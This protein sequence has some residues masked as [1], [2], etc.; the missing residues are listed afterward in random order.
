MSGELTIKRPRLT[1]Y[2]TFDTPAVT[3]AQVNWIQ[4]L[5]RLLGLTQADDAVFIWRSLDHGFL[6]DLECVHDLVLVRLSVLGTAVSAADEAIPHLRRDDWADLWQEAAGYHQYVIDHRDRLKLLGATAVYS[7]ISSY[8]SPTEWHDLV[9]YHSTS[10]QR[11]SLQLPIGELW[12]MSKRCE[13]IVEFHYAIMVGCEEKYDELPYQL[14]YHRRFWLAE[15]A[16]FRLQKSWQTKNDAIEQQLETS[17][18]ILRRL[19]DYI[20]VVEPLLGGRAPH[21]LVE[22]IE[23]RWRRKSWQLHQT[24][25]VEHNRLSHAMQKQ[26]HTI[27][28]QLKWL[29]LLFF[30]G[31]G[32]IGWRKSVG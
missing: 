11:A 26:I 17:G 23:T 18:E 9:P 31:A 22:Q 28:Q 21:D 19:G 7:A 8:E 10:N 2:Y 6:L 14:L 24:Q 3:A 16:R 29:T 20:T 30:C 25:F 4:R 5:A 32:L 12:Q 1:L 15:V 27:N 13:P